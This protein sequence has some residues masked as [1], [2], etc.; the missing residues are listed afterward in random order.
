M[1]EL[2]ALVAYK[3]LVEVTGV[4]LFAEIVSKPGRTYMFTNEV[5]VELVNRPQGLDGALLIGHMINS[6]GGTIQKENRF[7][8]EE[9]G[10]VKIGYGNM[11]S[12]EDWS[13]VITCQN[14]KRLKLVTN[15][16][17]LGKNALRAIGQ[18]RTKTVHSLVAELM[19]A[20]PNNRALQKVFAFVDHPKMKIL[21]MKDG[22]RIAWLKPPD[23]E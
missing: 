7:L 4:D 6:S 16:V 12:P 17:N 21:K 19:E 23:S 10:E 18:D 20:D 14:H 9:D 11:V 15:D 5:A 8:V 3:N 13:Q 2:F 22:D 1:V